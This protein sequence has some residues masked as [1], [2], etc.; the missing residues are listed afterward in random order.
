MQWTGEVARQI[1]RWMADGLE[2]RDWTHDLDGKLSLKAI[3]TRCMQRG[4]LEGIP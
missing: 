2:V 3:C 4:S 1:V